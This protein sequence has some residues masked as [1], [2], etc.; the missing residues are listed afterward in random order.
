MKLLPLGIL[1][2]NEARISMLKTKGLTMRESLI[3]PHIVEMP[4]A[5]YLWKMMQLAMCCH[6]HRR[7]AIFSAVEGFLYMLLEF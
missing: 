1:S 5:S 4:R 3:V 2:R 7:P 6:L